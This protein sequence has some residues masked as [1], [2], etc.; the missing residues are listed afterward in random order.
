MNISTLL[1]QNFRQ[2]SLFLLASVIGLSINVGITAFLHEVLGCSPRFSFA[3]ALVVAYSA[4]FLN[5]RKW[6]FSSN[7]A[8][9]GQVIRF[10]A[11]SLSFRLLEYLVFLLVHLVFGIYYLAAVLI[12]LASFYLFKFAA[13]KH[14]VFTRSAAS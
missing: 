14:L 4:N 9:G 7:V 10:L 5:N 12:S 1:K 13:Y 11:I 8:P 6:V 3:V 2:A